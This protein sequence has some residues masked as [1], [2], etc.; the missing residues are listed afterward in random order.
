MLTLRAAFAQS[1]TWLSEKIMRKKM[2]VL[3]SS[4]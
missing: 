4:F 1:D 2:S 3:I